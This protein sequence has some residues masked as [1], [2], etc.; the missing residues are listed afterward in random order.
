MRLSIYNFFYSFIFSLFSR[1]LS[2]DETSLLKNT[3][4]FDHLD[5]VSFEKC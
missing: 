4:L 5:K 2:P 3:G 1:A